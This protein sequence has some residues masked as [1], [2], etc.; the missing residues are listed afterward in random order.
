MLCDHAALTAAHSS[1]H[2]AAPAAVTYRPHRLLPT[3]D[4]APHPNLAVANLTTPGPHHA[5][6]HHPHVPPST[7]NRQA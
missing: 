2:T 6:L 1:S 5:D 7:M 3:L 4:E